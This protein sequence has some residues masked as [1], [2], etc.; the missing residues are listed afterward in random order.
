MTLNES[1]Q[2]FWAPGATGCEETFACLKR[3]H[4]AGFRTSAIIEPM[5]DAENIVQLY[6]TIS[7]YIT[8]EILVGPMN[9][10]ADV[11]KRNVGLPGI[12]EALAEIEK[13]QTDEALWKVHGWL[14]GLPKVRFKDDMRRALGLPPNDCD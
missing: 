11:R 9:H 1:L 7:P 5:L 10:L 4:A 2:K 8:D 6:E 12:G 14:S 13:W 3:G